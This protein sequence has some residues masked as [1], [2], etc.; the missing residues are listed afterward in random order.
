[1]IVGILAAF[2]LPMYFRTIERS[3]QAEVTNFVAE[4]AAAQNR[5]ASANGVYW[6]GSTAG[7]VGPQGPLPALIYF[8]YPT[9]TS[10][11]GSYMFSFSRSSPPV[12][13]NPYSLDY[14]GTMSAVVSACTGDTVICAAF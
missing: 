13:V 1:M 12:G 7:A 14:T 4:L 6:T 10:G 9:V 5:Y 11:A 8:D 3:R 2:A